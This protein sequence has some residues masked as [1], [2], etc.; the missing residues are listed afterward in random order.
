MTEVVLYD[1]IFSK[2][3]FVRSDEK[4]VITDLDSLAQELYF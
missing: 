3:C 1:I 4:L 2:I